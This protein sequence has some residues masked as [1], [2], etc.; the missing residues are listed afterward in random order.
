MEFL[1]RSFLRRHFAVKPSLASQNVGSFLRLPLG[2]QSRNASRPHGWGQEALNRDSGPSECD[3]DQYAG[4][5][6]TIGIII[7]KFK[8]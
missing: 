8:T 7:P 2:S 4:C 1:R 6:S 5:T 3:R